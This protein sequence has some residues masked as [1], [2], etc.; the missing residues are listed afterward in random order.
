LAYLAFSDHEHERHKNRTISGAKRN[1]YTIVEK[2]TLDQQ[3]P[4]EWNSYGLALAL[5]LRKRSN[6]DARRLGLS[7]S[8]VRDLRLDPGNSEISFSLLRIVPMNDGWEGVNF[9]VFNDEQDVDFSFLCE[10]F[11]VNLLQVHV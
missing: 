11:E 7:F 1:E 4:D 5:T 9:K 8:Q 3:I 6:S 10:D 2:F